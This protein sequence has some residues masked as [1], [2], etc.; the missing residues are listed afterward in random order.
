MHYSDGRQAGRGDGLR[1][2]QRLQYQ[3]RDTRSA[4]ASQSSISQ[5]LMQSEP[6]H[7]E[8][9]DSQDSLSDTQSD[10]GSE[11][12]PGAFVTETHEQHPNTTQILLEIRTDVK[13]MNKNYDSL[14]KKSERIKERKQAT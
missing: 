8:H 1:W 2:S 10:H 11:H 7:Q 3:P 4:T 12:E 6:E 14:D 5:W 9:Q 13:R